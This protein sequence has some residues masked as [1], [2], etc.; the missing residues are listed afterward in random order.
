MS[1]LATLLLAN[2]LASFDQRIK[3]YDRGTET[4]IRETAASL[5]RIVER[6]KF[7]I[8]QAIHAGRWGADVGSF[9]RLDDPLFDV[10]RK[11][12]T[13]E[14]PEYS[15]E[16]VLTPIWCDL[17]LWAALNHLSLTFELTTAPDGALGYKAY[18]DIR[19]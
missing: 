4:R 14:E 9:I 15:H 18:V 7:D 12:V 8:S 10:V 17:H 1:N 13:N 6:I 19:Y 11:L 16:R 5:R 2:E 3:Q